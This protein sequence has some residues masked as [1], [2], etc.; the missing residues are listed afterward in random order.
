[1]PTNRSW[2]LSRGK[3]KVFQD[4]LGTDARKPRLKFL[5][6]VEPSKKYKGTTM[7]ALERIVVLPLAVCLLVSLYRVLHFLTLI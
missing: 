2:Q 4:E 3:R 6:F 7:T 5:S 1:M